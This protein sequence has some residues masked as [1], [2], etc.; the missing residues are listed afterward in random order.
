M[1][2]I[3]FYIMMIKYILHFKALFT[4]QCVSAAYIKGKAGANSVKYQILL[5]IKNLSQFKTLKNVYHHTF[6]N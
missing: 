5:S 3:Y 2:V 6:S 4:L 1:Q